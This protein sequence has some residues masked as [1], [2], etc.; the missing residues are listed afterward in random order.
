M[1]AFGNIC[2]CYQVRGPGALGRRNLGRNLPRQVAAGFTLSAGYSRPQNPDSSYNL[3]ALHDAVAWTTSE[4][5]RLLRH[6]RLIKSRSGA[7]FSCGGVYR[8]FFW[9]GCLELGISGCW[10]RAVL[11]PV[12]FSLVIILDF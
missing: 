3:V 1:R 8:A 6:M 2:G 10:E 9:P 4:Q 11:A 5:L 12:T 7:A